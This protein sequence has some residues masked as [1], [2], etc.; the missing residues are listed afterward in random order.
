MA[1]GKYEIKGII[2]R[3]SDDKCKEPK[4]IFRLRNYII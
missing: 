2:E 1:E 4:S 3:I